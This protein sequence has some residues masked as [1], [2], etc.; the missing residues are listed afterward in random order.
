[1]D[2]SHKKGNQMTTGRPA[3]VIESLKLTN[4]LTNNQLVQANA[5]VQKLEAMLEKIIMSPEVKPEDPYWHAYHCSVRVKNNILSGKTELALKDAVD[6]R[7]T[8]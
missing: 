6:I 5:V 3:L 2:Q 4:F 8:I 7:K 1:M